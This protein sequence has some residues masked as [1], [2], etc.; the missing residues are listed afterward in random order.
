MLLP[1]TAVWVGAGVFTECVGEG[2]G[3]ILASGCL[4]LLL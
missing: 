1:H 4:G 2:A 3:L